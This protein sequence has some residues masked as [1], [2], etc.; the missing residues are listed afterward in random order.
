MPER[1]RGDLASAA[2]SGT[3]RTPARRQA[4]GVTVALPVRDGGELLARTLAALEGQTVEHALLVCDSGSTDGS[5]AL[6]RAR[7]ARV[8]EISPQRVQSR[9]DAKLPDERG[10][11]RAR[12]AAHA[13]RRA[14]GR[15]LAREAAR[16]IR[17]GRRRGHRLRALP[18]PARRVARGAPGARAA[19]S[20]RSP[21]RASRGSIVSASRSVHRARPIAGCQE[22]R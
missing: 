5:V 17:A 18:S 19:G 21:P 12:R 13:G 6:A 7:G 9:E 20:G 4:G 2:P 3:G 1:A 11:E 10:D 15:A 14:R 22:S 8:I 16:R